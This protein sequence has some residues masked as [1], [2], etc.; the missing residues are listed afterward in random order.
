MAR[1]LTWLVVVVAVILGVSGYWYTRS[2]P[3]ALAIVD[4]ARRWGQAPMRPRRWLGSGPDP[5]PRAR[6]VP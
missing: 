4:A 3:S 5:A 6:Y 1:K 2:R